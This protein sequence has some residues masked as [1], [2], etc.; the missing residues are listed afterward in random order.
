[1]GEVG[2]ALARV[3]TDYDLQWLDDT[4]KPV[5]F[6]DGT[7]Q[8]EIMHVCFPYSDKFIDYVK[9]YQNKYNPKFTVI[10]STVP[11]GT[12]VQVG[13][14]HSP[15]R[16]LHPNLESGIRTFPK[17]LGG[18]RASEVADYFRRAGLKVVLFNKSE[19]TEAAKLFDTE[20]YRVCIEF[21]HRVK[22]L[23]DKE[24]LSYH[25][26]YTLWNQTYNEGYTELGH[27]EFVRP[28]LQ[29]IMKEIG[30]HC[31]LPNKELIKLSEDEV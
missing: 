3:L 2:Q 27:S 9:E 30:G 18:E 17:F 19:T 1:M 22:K 6:Q 5:I 7:M 26:V 4:E 15:I 14:V 25:E 13:A 16:G 20:Y 8:P 21:S 12:C 23:C 31:V 29:P 10:H 11:V 28:V 24:G